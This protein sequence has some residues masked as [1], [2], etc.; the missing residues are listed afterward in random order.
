MR[1]GTTAKLEKDQSMERLLE[2][3]LF[4]IIII[5]LDILTILTTTITFIIVV[6]HMTTFQKNANQLQRT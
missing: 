2:Q 6:V 1:R 5:I 3:V 4:F